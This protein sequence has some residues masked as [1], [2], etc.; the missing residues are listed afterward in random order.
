MEERDDLL[1]DNQFDDQDLLE[2]TPSKESDDED[3]DDPDEIKSEEIEMQK[4]KHILD[5]K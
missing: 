2:F 3:L 4:F 1:F 5:S